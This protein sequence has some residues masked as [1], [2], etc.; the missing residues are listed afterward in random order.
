MFLL[1]WWRCLPHP[2]THNATTDPC[3]SLSM[4]C[5]GGLIFFPRFQFM[6]SSF[7][8]PLFKIADSGSRSYM[9]A[10]FLSL[11]ECFGWFLT[12]ASYFFSPPT[13]RAVGLEPS[14]DELKNMI[15]EVDGSGTI[16]TNLTP[17]HPPSVPHA[18]NLVQPQVKTRSILLNLWRWC[19]RM[20]RIQQKK[21]RKLLLSSMQAAGK[22][23]VSLSLSSIP[24]L[25]KIPPPFTVAPS[26][27]QN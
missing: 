22:E 25:T 26:A 21:L 24:R 23:M 19:Q 14:D 7:H 6:T 16:Y 5:F 17:P 11:L 8:L 4:P 10:Y 12:F 1:A 13:Y 3:T 18:S 20:V 9:P 27:K 15:T 2:T